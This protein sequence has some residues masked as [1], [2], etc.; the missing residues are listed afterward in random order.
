[1]AGNGFSLKVLDGLTVSSGTDQYTKPLHIGASVSGSFH[2]QWTVVSSGTTT[3]T[4]WV[5]NKNSPDTSDDTDW[6]QLSSVV[7]QGPAGS[8]GK[9]FLNF[10]NVNARWC[11]LKFAH[12][13]GTSSTIHTWAQTKK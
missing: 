9:G 8:D 3:N 5:S 13:S 12:A 6:V 2:S 4:F 10:A 1:M 11:R 7:V